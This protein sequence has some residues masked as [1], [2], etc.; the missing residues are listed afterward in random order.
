MEE[1]PL[2]DVKIKHMIEDLLPTKIVEVH[3]EK[4]NRRRSITDED[5]VGRFVLYE[6]VRVWSVSSRCEYIKELFKWFC[7][8]TGY[9]KKAIDI[10]AKRETQISPTSP[11]DEIDFFASSKVKEI[12]KTAV[13]ERERRKSLPKMVF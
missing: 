2:N 6:A 11:K 10:V 12:I 1:F 3:D 8:C 4:L 7:C 5:V 9:R 13:V